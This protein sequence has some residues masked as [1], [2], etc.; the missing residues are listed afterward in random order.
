MAHHGMQQR[1][2]ERSLIIAPVIFPGKAGIILDGVVQ[3]PHPSFC[4]P[5]QFLHHAVFQER[6]FK[7][8]FPIIARVYV[9]YPA[10]ARPYLGDIAVYRGNADQGC[11][12]AHD[13][14]LGIIEQAVGGHIKTQVSAVPRFRVLLHRFADAAHSPGVQLRLETRAAP[15]GVGA[16]VLRLEGL[17]IPDLIF[18]LKRRRIAAVIP[19]FRFF[20]MNGFHAAVHG[21]FEFLG[22]V[23]RK[24]HRGHHVGYGRAVD[25]SFPC[26]VCLGLVSMRHAVPIAAQIVLICSPGNAGHQMHH[27]ARFRKLSYPFGHGC[28]RAVDHHKIALK[29][30]RGDELFAFL[31]PRAFFLPVTDISHMPPPPLFC[32]FLSF[33]LKSVAL[34]SIK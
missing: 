5:A 31:I 20:H 27:I 29:I 8:A 32:C 2:D 24:S 16:L 1:R 17:V 25:H 6:G 3:E 15:M 14:P 30:D 21:N 22:Q 26:A 10:G 11:F 13:L 7:G 9:G 18:P 12:R 4:A 23:I 34:S 19:E 28:V 33:Y